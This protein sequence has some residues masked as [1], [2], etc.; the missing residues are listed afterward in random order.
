MRIRP[1]NIEEDLKEASKSVF[2]LRQGYFEGVLNFAEYFESRCEL[3]KKYR[4]IAE[5]V[6]R[7]RIVRR[8][9]K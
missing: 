8:G 6:L 5:E 9:D 3:E 1:L 7:K 4:G 2:R